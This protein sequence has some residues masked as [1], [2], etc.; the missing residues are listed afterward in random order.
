MRIIRKRVR[1]LME[2]SYQGAY[3]LLRGVPELKVLWTYRT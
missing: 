3:G 1:Q 2:S